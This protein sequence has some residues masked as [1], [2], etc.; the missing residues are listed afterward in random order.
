M[1]VLGEQE[2]TSPQD[3]LHYAPRRRAEGSGPRLSTVT[4]AVGETKFDGP[5]RVG[6]SISP[7]APS[8]SLDAQL[9]DAVS[10]SLRRHLD[11]QVVPEPPAFAQQRSRKWLMVG[12]GIAAAVGVAAVVALLLVTVMPVSRDGGARSGL[13]AAVGFAQPRGDNAAKSALSQFRSVLVSGEGDQAA[14]REQSERLLQQFVQWRQKA[15][16]AQ[17]QR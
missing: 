10:E 11:P 6:A 13:A 17:Q 15:D 8:S 3:P 1:S 2:P 12:G 14:T 7:F 9:E 4:S 5:F 16:S